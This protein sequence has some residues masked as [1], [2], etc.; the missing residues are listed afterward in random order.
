MR[1]KRKFGWEVDWYAV[2]SVGSVA[3]FVSGFACVPKIVFADESKYLNI[4]SYFDNLP[5]S[6]NAHLSVWYES[7][8][9]Q[10]LNGF[11]NQ[12]LEAKKGICT[13]YDRYYSSIYELIAVPE[14]EIK[15]I[16][17]PH[18]VQ[19]FLLHIKFEDLIFAETEFID[20]TKFFDCEKGY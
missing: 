11:A 20:V 17:L 5:I 2:D 10:S 14:N 8:K 9:S 19:N 18:E 3:L 7:R 15:I 12:I 1:F 16:T 6:T 13:F 4:I